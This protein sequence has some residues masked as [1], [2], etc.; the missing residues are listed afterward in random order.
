VLSDT[1]PFPSDDL[2]FSLNVHD[3]ADGLVPS[4]SPSII[5]GLEIATSPGSQYAHYLD[6]DEL[7]TFAEKRYG[8]G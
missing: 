3:K 1:R 2:P 5:L 7:S 6:L 8:T 4:T